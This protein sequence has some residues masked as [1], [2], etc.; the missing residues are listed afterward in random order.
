[1]LKIVATGNYYAGLSENE[2][3][4]NL[5]ELM[6]PL[7]RERFRRI[8]RFTELCLLGSALCARDYGQVL[9]ADTGIYIASGFAGIDSTAT[10]H[11]QVFQQGQLPKPANFI[12]TLSNSAGYYVARNL[13]LQSQNMFVSRGS[14]SLVAA[15][16]MVELDILAGVIDQ[17]LVGVVDEC[18]DN[19]ADHRRRQGL[20]ADAELAE[21]SHWF[22][23]RAASQSQRNLNQFGTATNIAELQQRLQPWDEQV[24][25]VHVAP[26]ALAGTPGVAQCFA[27]RSSYDAPLAH[28]PS[29]SAGIAMAWLQ[30]PKG[31]GLL[32]INGYSDGCLHFYLLGGWAQ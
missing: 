2:S 24:S 20:A 23:L 22:L 18:G 1:M 15:L 28:Y 30:Q 27:D 10:L 25:H 6:A 14:G 12:N 26:D 19:L 4:A 17:A 8:D 9:A 11:Q 29:R 5:R 16:Q 32:A 13:Q 3:R 21:G 7:C 31:R